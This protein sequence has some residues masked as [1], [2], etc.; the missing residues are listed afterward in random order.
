MTELPKTRE[1]ENAPVGNIRAGE[2]GE[3]IDM[4]GRDAADA[5]RDEL[6]GR[7]A[8]LEGQLS[9]RAEEGSKDE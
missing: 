4:V 2:I 1:Y 8:E 5:M 7:I 6:L 3:V 9:A